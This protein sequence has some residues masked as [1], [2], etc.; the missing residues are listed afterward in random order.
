MITFLTGDIIL[1]WG[2]SILLNQS[3]VLVEAHDCG[4][5]NTPQLIYRQQW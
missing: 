4:E 3:A 5:A 2:G 1:T